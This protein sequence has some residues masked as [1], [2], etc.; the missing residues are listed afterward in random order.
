MD[1]S[2]VGLSV[3]NILGQKVATLVNQYQTSGYYN[4]VWLPFDNNGNKLENGLYLLKLEIDNESVFVNRLL[5][6][7]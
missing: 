2:Q 5:L 7:Q 6:G 1:G 3:S 4:L